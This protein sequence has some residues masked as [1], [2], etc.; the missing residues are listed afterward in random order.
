[1][2]SPLISIAVR[3]LPATKTLPERLKAE[4]VYTDRSVEMQLLPFLT[5]QQNCLYVAIRLRKQS[6]NLHNF[7]GYTSLR[8]RNTLFFLTPRSSK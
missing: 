3:L 4:S 7:S 5:F 1:M 8:N 2:R 6:F